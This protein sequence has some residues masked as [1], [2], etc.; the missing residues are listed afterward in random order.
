MR[1]AL[2][3]SILCIGMVACQLR[4]DY[5]DVIRANT[6]KIVE[7]EVR[8]F[9]LEE[10]DEALISEHREMRLAKWQETDSLLRNRNDT[11][12]S[13][14]A[15]TLLALSREG[16]PYHPFAVEKGVLEVRLQ[17]AKAQLA[18][19]NHDLEHNL[20]PADSVDILVKAERQIAERILQEADTMLRRT[21]AEKEFTAGWLSRIDST[22]ALLIGRVK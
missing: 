21:K 20:L 15:A 16:E 4:P 14:Q 9:A 3:I 12:D 6:N 10:F 1:T 2:T 17:R 19:L 8:E 5:S 13:L 22:T 18:N 11:L 7:L